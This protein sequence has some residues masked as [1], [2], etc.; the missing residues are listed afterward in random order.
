MSDCVPLREA[1]RARRL[2]AAEI[3]TA[4][5]SLDRHEQWRHAT[6]SPVPVT[7]LRTAHDLGFH[8]GLDKNWPTHVAQ[9]AV[10]Q[11]D[12][13]DRH[14][15]DDQCDDDDRRDDDRRDDD[16]RDSDGQRDPA[17]PGPRAGAPPPSESG[18]KR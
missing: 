5:D 10:D 3:L 7:C 1:V 14:E 18:A 13:D 6:V 8:L 15:D 16:R 12:D 9:A 17:R 11:L 4:A 2:S